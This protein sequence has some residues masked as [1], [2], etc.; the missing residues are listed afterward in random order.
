MTVLREVWKSTD[1]DDQ[2]RKR[3]RTCR[4]WKP[5]SA[6]Y[7]KPDHTD[8]LTG[9]CAQCDRNARILGRYGITAER[10]DEM[11]AEQGGGC[12]ICRRPSKGNNLSVD[13]DHACCSTRKKSCGKCVRG[14]LCEDCNRAIGMF[15]DD[16]ERLKRAL[17]YLGG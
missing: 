1:R 9:Y 11:L 7:P 8:G 14:L 12:A 10:F 6:F 16:H 3:C 4:E 5:E 17:E 15:E 2:G 13:H